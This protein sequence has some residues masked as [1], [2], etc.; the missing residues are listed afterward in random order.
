MS[1]LPV[2]GVPV[3]YAGQPP[4]AQLNAMSNAFSF[5]LSKVA[6]RARRAATGAVT[7]GGH[8]LV[9]WDTVDEDP[10]TGWAAGSPTIYTVQAGGWYLCVGTVSLG[11]AAAAG[12][13]L[14][15]AFCINGL[16]QTGQPA[17][18]PGWEG[19]ELFIPTGAGDPKCVAGY[20]EGYCNASDQISLDVFLSG[21]P[22]A[23]LTWAT[24]AGT[25]SR[26]EI[27][28]TGV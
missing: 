7:K 20:W 2:P 13:V 23:N 27:L 6:F 8:T 22:A 15:P 16:S 18:G 12:T 5:L 26:I 17:A 11:S 28:W 24:A 14:I 1:G 4:T 3:F 25:Q 10:Y 9:P 21:E 19:P